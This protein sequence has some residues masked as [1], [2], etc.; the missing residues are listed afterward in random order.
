MAMAGPSWL[1]RC[2]LGQPRPGRQP[3]PPPRDD[4]SPGAPAP[5]RWPVGA[6]GAV[7]ALRPDC[8]LKVHSF[9]VNSWLLWAKPDSTWSWQLTSTPSGGTRLLTRI[10]VTYDWRHPATALF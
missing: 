8:A 1:S 3:G 5:R 2:R 4:D 6:D 9:A 10:R 7:A